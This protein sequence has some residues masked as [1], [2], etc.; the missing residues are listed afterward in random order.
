MFMLEAHKVTVNVNN[1]FAIQR[2]TIPCLILLSNTFRKQPI[3]NRKVNV[4]GLE[5]PTVELQISHA[6]AVLELVELDEPA[7]TQHD[8]KMFPT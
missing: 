5:F 8:A 2:H 3:Q 4:H 1:I 6:Q 7:V